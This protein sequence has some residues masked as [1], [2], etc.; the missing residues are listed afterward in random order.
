MSWCEFV[1]VNIS[2]E[3][4]FMDWKPLSLR[5]HSPIFVADHL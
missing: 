3:A 5:L 4:L 2:V 1:F